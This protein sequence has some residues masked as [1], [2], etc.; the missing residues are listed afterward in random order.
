MK[1]NNQLKDSNWTSLES[2]DTKEIPPARTGNKRSR[3][4]RACML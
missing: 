3:I 4:T 1:I 2:K